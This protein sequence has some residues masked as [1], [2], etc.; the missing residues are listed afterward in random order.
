MNTKLLEMND[1]SSF[2]LLIIKSGINKMF[3]FLNK[4]EYLH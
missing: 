1:L 4:S 2:N 3:W